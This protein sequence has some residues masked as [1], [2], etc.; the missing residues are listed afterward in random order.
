LRKLKE[1]IDNFVKGS[2]SEMTKFY[3]KE[4]KQT[5]IFALFTSKTSFN[6]TLQ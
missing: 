6:L 1:K 2:G 5:E 3:F 4:T